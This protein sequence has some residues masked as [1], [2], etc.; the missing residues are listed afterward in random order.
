MLCFTEAGHASADEALTIISE[1][2]YNGK[3]VTERGWKFFLHLIGQYLE[4]NCFYE[5][6]QASSLFI[7]LMVRA[8]N[9]FKNMDLTGENGTPLNL[10]FQ[11]IAKVFQD[12]QND[13]LLAMCG[14]SLIIALMEHL[15][16]N[17]QLLINQI[18]N[19]NMMYM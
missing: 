5:P 10:L 7:Y 2:V 4:G 1:I 6:A 14:V 11:F 13:E 12:G 19:I 17:D 8:P 16:Q 18:D 15:G 9:E 3:S